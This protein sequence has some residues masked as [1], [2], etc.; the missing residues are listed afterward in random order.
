[1]TLETLWDRYAAA[2]SLDAASRADELAA[3]VAHDIAYCDPNGVIEGRDALSKYMHAFR[4]SVPGGSFLIT[5]VRH[6]HDRS[7]ALWKL[8]GPA[9]QELQTGASAAFHDHDGRLKAV[10]GFFDPPGQDTPR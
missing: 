2:W 5:S 4:E 8:T 1:M 7:L 10:T 3:C 9:G 6:H